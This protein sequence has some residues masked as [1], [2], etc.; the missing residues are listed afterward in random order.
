LVLGMIKG[1]LKKVYK[2]NDQGDLLSV[3]AL[4]LLEFGK[5]DFAKLFGKCG[6]G[7]HGFLPSVAFKMDLAEM[8]GFEIPGSE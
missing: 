4:V 7:L 8:P 1:E 6:Y 5:R 3:V 2:E